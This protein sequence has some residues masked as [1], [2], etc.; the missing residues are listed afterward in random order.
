MTKLCSVCGTENR[1]DA[2]FCRACGTPMAAAQAAPAAAIDGQESNVCAEC[3]F[4]N[5]PG[6]RYCANCGISLATAA[7]AANAEAVPAAGSGSPASAGPPPLSYPSFATVPP[8][9]SAAEATDH[10]ALFDTRPVP[11]IPDPAAAIALRQQEGL[12][13]HG[14]TTATF[15]AAPA[16]NRARLVVAIVAAV[17][18]VAAIAA[19]AVLL[20]TGQGRA[21]QTR[22]VDGSDLQT[23]VQQLDQLVDDNIR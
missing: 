4:H 14:D 22:E 16:P 15:H 9:P 13:S 21:V 1:D 12:Q 17:L 8:Y 10:S 11:D 6:I 7:G 2:K 18:V 3:G 5:K 23:V 19:A 20:T